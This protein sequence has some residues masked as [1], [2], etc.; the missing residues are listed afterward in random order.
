MSA[1]PAIRQAMHALKHALLMRG[2][3][4]NRAETQRIAAIL[5]KAAT[6]IATGQRRE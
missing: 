4:W 1:P 5:E 6:D 2:T 3:E